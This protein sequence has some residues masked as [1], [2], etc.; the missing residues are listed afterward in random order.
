MA[1][2]F[3]RTSVR[4]VFFGRVARAGEGDPKATSLTPE[5]DSDQILTKF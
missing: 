4:L 5:P 1:D 3:I 2:S